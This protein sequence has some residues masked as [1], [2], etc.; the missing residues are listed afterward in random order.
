[1]GSCYQHVEPF[2]S[3]LRATAYFKYRFNIADIGMAA[4]GIQNLICSV[5][6]GDRFICNVMN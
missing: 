4:E 6:S 5:S 3:A 1:M 2:I